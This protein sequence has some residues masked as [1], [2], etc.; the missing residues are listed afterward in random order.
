[1]ST[2]VEAQLITVY[3]AWKAQL[4]DDEDKTLE[5][6]E[7]AYIGEFFDTEEL[8]KYLIDDAGMADVD[9]IINKIDD[10]LAPYFRFDYA[11]YGRDLE[12]GGD[13]YLIEERK[14]IGTAGHTISSKHYFWTNV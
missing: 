9:S 13:V 7:Q 1:M 12:L 4:N 5:L 14:P 8:A 3:K 10:S 2:T 6:F 11:M